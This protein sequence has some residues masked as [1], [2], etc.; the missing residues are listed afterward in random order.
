MEEDENDIKYWFLDKVEE[1]L[2]KEYGEDDALAGKLYILLEKWKELNI[3]ENIANKRL[4][5]EVDYLTN[6]AKN[7][8]DKRKKMMELKA[9]IS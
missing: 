8:I 4:R 9:T 5:D 2:K 3:A 6:L 7:F 1:N